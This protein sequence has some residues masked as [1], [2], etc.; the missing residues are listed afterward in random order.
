MKG[1]DQAVEYLI[2]N[3]IKNNLG[4][5]DKWHKVRQDYFWTIPCNDILHANIAGLKS[6]Y[7]HYV[8]RKKKWMDKA[9]CIDVMTG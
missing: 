7:N 5:V 2:Q 4:T 6:V 9:E 8:V 3:N 1:I